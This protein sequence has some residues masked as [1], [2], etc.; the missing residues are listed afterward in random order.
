V[1]TGAYKRKL[2]PR[3][4]VEDRLYA[5]AALEHWRKVHGLSQR[6][7][8]ARIG[9]SER[10]CSWAHWE[11]GF[12]IPPYGTLLRIMAATGLGYWVDSENRAGGDPALRLDA[13]R[14]QWAA[15]MRRR[16]RL[17][18]ERRPLA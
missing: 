16:R 15:N 4:S 10:S 1:S 18:D 7:A 13:D 14:A 9:Y 17:R 6:E 2:R 11:S 12:V 5:P 3:T 8:Q